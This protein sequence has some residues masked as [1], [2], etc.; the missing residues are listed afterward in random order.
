MN[1]KQDL[2]LNIACCDGDF[3][4]IAILISL[5]SRCIRDLSKR[6]QLPGVQDAPSRVAAQPTRR[7]GKAPLAPVWTP[8]AAPATVAQAQPLMAP[9]GTRWPSSNQRDPHW[10][11]AQSPS[12]MGS[13]LMQWHLS[14]V[15]SPTR[16]DPAPATP[17]SLGA[18]PSS[19]VST[20]QS[21]SGVLPWLQ[22]D[23]PS[24]LGG[25]DR[26]AERSSG[27][28]PNPSLGAGPAGSISGWS[29]DPSLHGAAPAGISSQ[30]MQA[31]APDGDPAGS[32]NGWEQVP[33]LDELPAGSS[34]GWGQE[35][36]ET[37]QEARRLM[38][39][40]RMPQ[41]PMH[42]ETGGWS[43]STED[44]RPLVV[45]LSAHTGPQAHSWKFQASKYCLSKRILQSSFTL[46]F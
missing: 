46:S 25:S 5:I 16:S 44:I 18:S 1:V 39:G 33:P 42:T 13:E 6:F 35:T 20:L 45:K 8:F 31:P 28:L 30:W 14:G 10:Q 27:W 37:L 15:P 9:V 32:A 17:S 24:Q 4:A 19:G 12:N 26:P 36:T 21:Y 29:Q 23:P 2:R 22:R 38:S 41:A 40:D 34:G 7:H 43:R 11:E 3:K